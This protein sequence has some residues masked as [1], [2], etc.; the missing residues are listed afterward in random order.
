MELEDLGRTFR[1]T[2]SCPTFL[3]LRRTA[4]FECCALDGLVHPARNVALVLVLTL[5]PWT[6]L[7]LGCAL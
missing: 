5:V 1:N 7:H 4:A 6:L 3:L 2:K